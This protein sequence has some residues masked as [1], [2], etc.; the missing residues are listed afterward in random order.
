MTGGV[1]LARRPGGRDGTDGPL[2]GNT[3]P[4]FVRAQLYYEAR[5]HDESQKSP[6]RRSLRRGETGA[7]PRRLP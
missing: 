7:R 1:F 3:R 6:V 5:T 2:Y 4:D